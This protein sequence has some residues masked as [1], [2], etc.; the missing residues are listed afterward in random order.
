MHDQAQIDP[1]DVFAIIND[2]QY[3]VV[4]LH[5]AI[6]T[7]KEALFGMVIESPRTLGDGDADVVGGY[8]RD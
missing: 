2:P 6:K 3:N 5:L 8:Q 7:P 4:R 1:A